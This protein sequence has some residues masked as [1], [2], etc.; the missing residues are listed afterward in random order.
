MMVYQKKKQTGWTP[1]NEEDSCSECLSKRRCVFRFV[2]RGGQISNCTRPYR[3]LFTD[4]QRVLSTKS[5][6]QFS[7]SE[8]DVKNAASKLNKGILRTEFVIGDMKSA[9]VDKIV[10]VVAA[11]KFTSKPQYR[12]EINDVP[13]P[14][15][16]RLPT[17]WSEFSFSILGSYKL[18]AEDSTVINS[19][20]E[21][22]RFAIVRNIQIPKITISDPVWQ[23]EME[24]GALETKYLAI[25]VNA[26]EP[27]FVDLTITQLV[28]STTSNTRQGK[29]STLFGSA[30]KVLI[31]DS[32]KHVPL[33]IP[34]N[35]RIVAGDEYLIT[36]TNRK[37]QQVSEMRPWKPVDFVDHYAISASSDRTL[38]S[39]PSI[40]GESYTI[41]VETTVP[42]QSLE[43]VADSIAAEKIEVIKRSNS[44]W[45]FK[46]NLAG[47]QQKAIPFRFTGRG[48]RN[49]I[50]GSEKL[51]YITVNNEV[52]L[53]EPLAISFDKDKVLTL[54]YKLNRALPTH[55]IILNATGARI[56]NCPPP[57]PVQN[58]ERKYTA[59]CSTEVLNLLTQLASK[60]KATPSLEIP[61]TISLVNREGG[62]ETSITQV[63]L[64]A[65]G[66]TNQLLL[67]QAKEISDLIST[68]GKK[69]APSAQQ[70]ILE[71]LNLAQMP[72]TGSTLRSIID[73]AIRIWQSQS[74]A[75]QRTT[76]F[77]K[78]V[79]DVV[80]AVAPRL[81]SLAFPL[82]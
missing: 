80:L 46:L 30:E 70:A 68:G 66:V 37:N 67:S 65:Y 22:P 6:S 10:R 35:R 74:N 15:D 42:G 24:S 21:S 60:L 2:S 13:H 34:Q 77:W 33:K 52:R 32:T 59:T 69:D 31:D 75:G 7:R 14:D 18:M 57:K 28:G 72:E 61:V 25:P 20:Y 23:A 50:L 82:L 49:Q 29:V 17:K 47:V 81:A 27:M 9:G 44:S 11:T 41:D 40:E 12:V 38:S 54:T 45:S 36:V 71:K 79:G 43:L 26:T 8:L 53:T 16:F 58:E 3:S 19:E 56:D 76:S 73:E 5:G 51:Y 64:S 78:K 62:R 1:E 39:L 63:S 4:R 48:T 55:T